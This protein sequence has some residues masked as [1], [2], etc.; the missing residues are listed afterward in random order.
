VAGEALVY[1]HFSV[2]LV[3]TLARESVNGALK[4]G[5]RLSINQTLKNWL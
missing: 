3:E 2:F 5:W 4:Q 1:L